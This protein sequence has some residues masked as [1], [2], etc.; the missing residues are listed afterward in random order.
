MCPFFNSYINLSCLFYIY[1]FIVLIFYPPLFSSSFFLEDNYVYIFIFLSLSIFYLYISI[2]LFIC[3][4][5][6][7]QSISV[8]LSSTCIHECHIV[9]LWTKEPKFFSLDTCTILVILW[10]LNWLFS[11]SWRSF[12]ILYFVLSWL[13]LCFSSKISCKFI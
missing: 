8:Y 3:L 4:F 11:K 10:F 6:F 13:S 9:I 12:T 1:C 2:Y 5:I 7:Y